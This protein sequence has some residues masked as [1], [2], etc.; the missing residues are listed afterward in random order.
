MPTTQPQSYENHSRYVFPYHG[1]LFLILVLNIVWSIYHAVVSFGMPAVMELAVSVALGL[2]F[3]YARQFALTVQDRVIRLEMRLRLAC[4]LPPEMRPAID[5]F[6][7]DQLVAMRFGSDEEMPE[8]ASKV[9][10]DNLT[11]RKAIKKLVKNWQADY[12]RA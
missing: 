12:L 10:A 2:I 3:V 7:V 11:D 1:I 8:L 6:T 5:R 9:L 4:V